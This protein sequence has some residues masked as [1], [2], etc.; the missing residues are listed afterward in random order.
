M[1]DKLLNPDF[2]LQKVYTPTFFDLKDQA[3]SEQLAQL[4]KSDPKIVVSNTILSQIAELI[5]NRHPQEKFSEERL[6]ALA[7]EELGNQQQ[8]YGLW[9]YYPWLR[10]L[11]H[12]LRKDDFISL[13][14][15]RNR[16]KITPEEQALLAQK[17]IALIGLS[18]GQSVAMSLTMERGYGELVIADF[19]I[20]ELTNINRIRS[21][22]HNIGLQ[23]T[24]AVAREIAEIDPYLK[25]TCFHEGV[26]AANLDEFLTANGRV[27]LLIDE[28]DSLEVKIMARQRARQLQIPVLMDTS[29]RGML[30]IER[31]DLEPQRP[32][33][34]GMLKPI[35]G[36]GSEEI[37]PENRTQ[38]LMTIIDF[39]KLSNEAKYSL[40][41]IGKT[42][43]TWPQLGASVTY[44]GGITAE[45]SRKVL[46]GKTLVSGRYYVDLDQI[47]Q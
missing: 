12:I 36:D 16:F 5:K 23:K 43:S 20:L 30:D 25:V 37:T 31:F 38:V 41:Q 47:I 2:S 1:L 4:L 15:S 29:D 42:I 18:V 24:V 39:D 3:D 34:H 32:L 33:F 8:T 35:F 28:C 44:G 22:V 13:R 7:L 14:T 10:K 46:L 26:T 45:M 11:I 9:V 17:K 21:G 40:G 6:Q 27:D 19:D